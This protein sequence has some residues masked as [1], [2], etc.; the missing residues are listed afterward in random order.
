MDNLVREDERLDDLQ[1]GYKIIQHP[2]KFCFGMDAV[3]LSSFAKVNENETV[4]DFGTGT[5]ILPV[6]LAA[7]TKGKHFTGLEIQP[8]SVEMAKRSILYNNLGSKIDIIEG[9][10]CKASEIFGKSKIDVVTSNP[11]YMTN[12]HGLKNPNDAKAIARHE[13]K[14]TLED[15]V[16]ETA[17][18]LKPG[19]RCYYVHRPFRIVEIF[20]QMRKY[21]LEPKR[22][23]LVYPYVDKEPNMVLIEGVRGGGAQLKV[24]PPLIVYSKQGKYTDEI[25]NIYGMDIPKE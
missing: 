14:C 5:G 16:R 15:I 22:M 13:L 8:E 4:V 17:A 6:L 25:Y 11:P 24:E 7:K 3:L 23:R 2:D 12:H 21:K 9:D 10:I 20:E 18:V 1:N 19:G